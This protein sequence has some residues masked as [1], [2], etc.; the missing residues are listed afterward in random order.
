[1]TLILNS[2][3]LL[4]Q[5]IEEITEQSNKKIKP[6]EPSQSTA[7]EYNAALQA[8]VKQIK[9]DIDTDIVPMLKKLEPQF[10]NDTNVKLFVVDSFVDDIVASITGVMTKWSSPQFKDLAFTAASS[11]V[12]T[13]NRINRDR[14]NK[15]MKS[16]GLDIFGDSP[17]VQDWLE[18]A[19]HDNANLIVTIPQQ[20]LDRVQSIVMTNVRA[21]N[22]AN[23]IS[24]QLQE[25][26]GVT[27]RRAELIARDQTAKLNGDLTSKRQQAS[28]FEYFQWIT[29]KDERVRETHTDIANAKTEYGKGIY[30][31]DD[32]PKK[33]GTGKDANTK[34]IPSQ[35]YQC[36]C[37]ARPVS[38]AEVEQNKSKA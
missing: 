18:L 4:A 2:S 36:R 15:S 33:G 35:D 3:E 27:Q 37:I 10:V 34:I 31:W 5:Q 21:G 23:N 26:F 25:Q 24:K 1:M 38:K 17:E 11:F 20:Y 30:R 12:E 9:K 16:F 22:R 28:G 6:V 8:L 19:T 14:F 29:S 13:A 32:P 7:V